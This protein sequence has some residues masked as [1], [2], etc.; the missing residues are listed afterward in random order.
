MHHESKQSCRF[1]AKCHMDISKDGSEYAALQAK[2][3]LYR[4]LP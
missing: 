4:M 1:V 2:S 3:I